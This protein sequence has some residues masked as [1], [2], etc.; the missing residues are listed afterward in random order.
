ME[1]IKAESDKSKKQFKNRALMV[2]ETL[3]GG[4]INYGNIETMKIDI[5]ET[6]HVALGDC[7]NEHLDWRDKVEKHFKAFEKA[8]LI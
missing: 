8:G 5:Y 7:K 1:R 4:D 6:A 2:I 3:V